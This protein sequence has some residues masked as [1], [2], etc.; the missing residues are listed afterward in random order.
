M[1]QSYLDQAKQGKNR[2][3]RY[4]LGV[5]LIVF[6]WLVVGGIVAAI[7]AIAWLNWQ[8]TASGVPLTNL[9]QAL[10]GLLQSPTLTAYVLNNLPF[11]CFYGGLW[12][13]IRRLHQRP[14]LSLLS[15]DRTF[16]GDR[17][18]LGFGLWF[19]LLGIP[20]L[21]DYGFHNESYQRIAAITHWLRFLP[22]AFVLTP[23]QVAAEELL[24]RG[25]LL[26]ALG[27]ISRNSFFLIGINGALFALPHLANP[28]LQRGAIWLILIYFAIG[29]FLALVTL[30]ENRL[31][32]ALGI[33]TANNILV[34]VFINSIDSAVPAPTLLTVQETGDP[35]L[36]L[37]LLLGQMLIFYYLCFRRSLRRPQLD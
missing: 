32:M 16:A 15:T 5:A 11:I 36:T 33:H 22:F 37:I 1:G 28:E 31:E 7:A 8:S 12:V 13:V 17:F 21:I 2:W 20:S 6:A 9:D 23:L 27:L 30:K 25:Y 10:M 34:V 18:W 4:V 24:F 3:W 19:L 29:A 35:R 26:Q 14:F